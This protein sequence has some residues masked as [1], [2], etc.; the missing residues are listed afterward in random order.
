MSPQAAGPVQFDGGACL[1]GIFVPA[2]G[3]ESFAQFVHPR[4]I[5]LS[6]PRTGIN[7]PDMKRWRNYIVGLLLVTLPVSLWAAMAAPQLCGAGADLPQTQAVDDAH[8]HHAMNMPAAELQDE[9]APGSR[10]H[11]DNGSTQPCC[12]TCLSACLASSLTAM[13]LS[14]ASLESTASETHF[15]LVLAARFL[16]DP[17]YPSLYRPPISQI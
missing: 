3:S 16:P 10:H 7:I 4:G 13:N 9:D 14:V 12:D 1:E 17:G 8:A 11:S 15:D 2:T 6:R 5:F